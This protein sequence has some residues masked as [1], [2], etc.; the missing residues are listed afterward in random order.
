MQKISSYLYPNRIEVIAN[1]ALDPATCPVEWKIVYQ[2]PI[3]IYKG[4]D[5]VIELEVKNA[6]QKR[7]DIFGKS[8]K[9]VLMDQA[10]REIETYNAT[11]VDDGSTACVKGVARI[12][13]PEADLN[14]LDPQHLKFTSYILNGDNTKTL[15][16]G[17]SKYG[18]QGFIDLL[19]GIIPSAREVRRYDTFQQET[20]Y[21]GRT[22]E[23]RTVTY[24]SSAVP[25]KY[26]EAIPTTST[27]VVVTLTNFVG[28]L[29]I[30]GTNKEII[31]HEAFLN[32]DFNI[33]VPSLNI[34]GPGTRS[35]TIDTTDLTYLRVYYIKTAGTVDYFTVAS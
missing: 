14:G 13:V 12:T 21:N 8:V 3:K 35:Y 7:L 33:T 4:V 26:Y 24:Y 32:P 30:Q 16:Y 20:N 15:L 34:V 1:V 29:G 25:V 17:D 5:N 22:F 2:K 28:T 31:G 10:S 11:V 6:D 19:D 18:A 27:T 23:E 9:F